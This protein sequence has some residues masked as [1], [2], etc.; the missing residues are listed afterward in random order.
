MSFVTELRNAVKSET[1]AYLQFITGKGREGFS[2]YAFVEDDDDSIFYQHV[3]PHFENVAFLGCGGKEGVLAIF[4]K[5]AD[6][7]DADGNLFFVDRDVEQDETRG[8]DAVL[9]TSGYS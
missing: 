9:R 6:D 4:S 3:L 2:A 1:S 8:G 7:G 5:L